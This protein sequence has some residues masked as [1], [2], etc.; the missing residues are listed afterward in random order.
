[1]PAATTAAAIGGYFL[2]TA[3]A[4][5]WTAFAVG[6]GVQTAIGLALYA[7]SGAG[8]LKNQSR[9]YNITA[10]GSAL[11]HQIVYGRTKVAGVRV[12]DHT[13]GGENKFLHRVIAFTGH[14]IEAFE[15]VYVNGVKVTT[16]GN[17]SGPDGFGE[18]S[19][20]VVDDSENPTRY[21]ENME[22]WKYLG[23]ED[24]AASDRLINRVNGIDGITWDSTYRLRGISYL[25]CRFKYDPDVYPNGVPEITAVIK[26]KKVEDPR[27]SGGPLVWT[28]NPILCIRDYIKSTSYGLGEDPSN[29]DDTFFIAAANICDQTD[30]LDATTR[31]TCNGAFTTDAAPVDIL[32]SMLTSCVGVLWYAQGS[33]RIKAGSYQ[34]PTL[35]LNKDN[36]RGPVN[37]STRHSRRDNFNG[38]RGTF[39]GSE[40]NWQTSDYEAVVSDA[41][42]AAD[43]GQES[44]A[45]LNLSFT[46]NS[47]E[48]RRN[49]RIVLEQNRQ[50]LTVQ[51]D[52]DLQAFKVQI[53]DVVNLTLDRYGW[54]DK[55]FE[56]TSWSFQVREDLTIPVKMTLR[57]TASTVYDEVDDGATYELDNTNLPSPYATQT[58]SSLSASVETDINEDGTTVLNIN[59]SW[60]VTDPSDIAYYEFEWKY[61]TEDDSAYRS[62][63]VNDT[64]W[65]LTGAKSNVSYTYRVRSVNQLGVKSPFAT[66]T[67]STGQDGTT[68]ENPTALTATGGY[69]NVYLSWTAPTTN[70]DGS[71]LKDLNK[72]NIYYSPTTQV[73]DGAA[74]IGDYTYIGS[75]SG[76]SFVWGG[77]EDATDYFFIVTATD[78]S[79]NEST[80]SN[81]ASATTNAALQDG[82]QG[83]QGIRGPGRYDAV[84][85]TDGNGQPLWP[86]D[87]AQTALDAYFTQA[88]GYEYGI[89]GDQLWLSWE[90]SVG[91][92]KEQ[93]VWRYRGDNLGNGDW[94]RQD[95][96]IDGSLIVSESISADRLYLDGLTLDTVVDSNGIHRLVVA[97]EGVGYEQIIDNSSTTFEDTFGGGSYSGSGPF[98][99]V[100]NNTFTMEHDGE[101]CLIVSITIGGATSGSSSSRIRLMVDGNVVRDITGEGADANG[102]FTFFHVEPKNEG[103]FSA[104]VLFDLDNITDPTIDSRVLSLQRYR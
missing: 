17:A 35:T 90:E 9:G 96:F 97:D 58:P 3:L 88:S 61:S 14:E 18:G 79:G 102:F 52:W 36:L 29:I 77:L 42:I 20:D 104:D 67:V 43:N 89:N 84:V 24:Q 103:N 100:D 34:S 49:A 31:Y 38:V 70:D 44:F 63:V 37:I 51:A 7:I 40:S 76:T 33:W 12:F 55:P 19:V 54:T 65:T 22:I 45:D 26:G 94:E 66:S 46:D 64:G 74:V 53:G 83:E 72:Y 93:R 2:P 6:L 91:V 25:Y 73:A 68:P 101:V 99:D 39:R 10:N 50:Q 75:S 71:P 11:D 8:A 48:A 47:I 62:Q 5:T 60:S 95:V 69:Q 28:D 27:I 13:T 16:F 59:F 23:A 87:G 78:F 30:T 85:D 92:P 1:M 4:G 81:E 57:E 80:R 15:E 98:S 82:A 21:A 86:A 56:V 32:Q 41:S